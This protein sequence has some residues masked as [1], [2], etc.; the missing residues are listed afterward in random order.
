M[1]RWGRKR[2]RTNDGDCEILN[3]KI[4]KLLNDPEEVKDEIYH[5]CMATAAINEEDSL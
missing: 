1:Q 5:F 2:L 3:N 4:M